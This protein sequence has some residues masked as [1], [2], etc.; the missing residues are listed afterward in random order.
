MRDLID[1]SIKINHF[2]AHF[3]LI[4]CFRLKRRL[5]AD[6][7]I[8]LLLCGFFQILVIYLSYVRTSAAFRFL[9]FL[10]VSFCAKECRE[11]T[12]THSNKSLTKC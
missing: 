7:V 6:L 11:Q 5:F 12:A 8:C 1:F 2:S 4:Q 9:I 3:F 10:T